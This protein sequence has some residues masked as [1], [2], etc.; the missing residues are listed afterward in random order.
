MA[1][2][3]YEYCTYVSPSFRNQGFTRNFGIKKI[4]ITDI[5]NT[6]RIRLMSW[7]FILTYIPAIYK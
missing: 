7:H 3:T 5:P 6:P 2:G 4:N 1:K